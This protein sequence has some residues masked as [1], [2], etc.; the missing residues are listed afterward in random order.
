M[1]WL[2]QMKDRQCRYPLLGVGAQTRFCA[3]EITTERWAGGRS[4][5]RYCDVHRALCSTGRQ[6]L[7]PRE[8]KPSTWEKRSARG[9][10]A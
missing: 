9:G 3:V 6:Q 10:V 8:Q 7:T 5:D 4:G 2:L 1:L